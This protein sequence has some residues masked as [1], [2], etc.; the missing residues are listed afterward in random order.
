MEETTDINNFV[1]DRLIECLTQQCKLASAI[2]TKIRPF[3]V[4]EILAE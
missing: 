1:V 2:F 4:S 3:R